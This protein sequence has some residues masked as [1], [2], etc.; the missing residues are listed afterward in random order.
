MISGGCLCGAVRYQA[1]GD[2][3]SAGFCHCRDCQKASG[4]GHVPI[5]GVPK[6]AVT[7]TGE[8]RCFSVAGSSG[9]ETKR[10]FCPVCG[11]M[12]FGEPGRPAGFY[13]ISAGTLDDP[14]IFE[15]RFALFTASRQPWDR[16]ALVLKEYEG[17]P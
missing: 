5:L 3:V 6:T 12:L 14:S 16:S 11:T 7:V 10:H 9:Q 8:T 15:P 13:G 17:M 2:P 1:A 4:T